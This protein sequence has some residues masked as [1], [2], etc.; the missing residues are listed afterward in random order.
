MAP[1]AS[2]SFQRAPSIAPQS[3]IYPT[4]QFSSDV[5]H[6]TET[7]SITDMMTDQISYLSSHRNLWILTLTSIYDNT[8]FSIE[9]WA[10]RYAYDPLF[11]DFYSAIT[12]WMYPNVFLLD[13]VGEQI[14]NGD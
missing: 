3:G 4:D 12:P 10:V 1:P 8:Y 6:W 9:D 7:D 13:F 11:W 2:S 5:N 14:H